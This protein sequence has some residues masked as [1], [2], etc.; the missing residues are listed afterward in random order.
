M[1]FSLLILCSPTSD[2]SRTAFCFAKAALTQ[3]HK[4]HRIFFYC[5]GVYHGSQ[6]PCP[7]QDQEN[8]IAL[9]QSLQHKYE[10]DIVVCIAAGLKRG[11]LDRVE[12]ERYEKQAYNLCA[13]FSLDGL[14]QLVD[15]S[16]H[17]DRLLTFGG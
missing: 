1:I 16:V 13:E 9:W 6:M 15:A 5:D 2:P 3:G 17:S 14:G 7:P 4:I 10:L 12:A 11:V 8:T